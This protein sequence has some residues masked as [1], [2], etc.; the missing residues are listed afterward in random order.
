VH[1]SL[2]Y[3][4]EISGGVGGMMKF[5]PFG[6]KKDK[7]TQACKHIFDEGAIVFYC[8]HSPYHIRMLPPLPVFKKEDWARVFACIER[9]LAKTAG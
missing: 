8:G 7:I 3:E 9:G 2:G 4:H 6:G 1:D 5:T